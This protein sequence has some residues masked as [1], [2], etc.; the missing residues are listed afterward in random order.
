[1]AQLGFN[2]DELYDELLQNENMTVEMVAA[3]SVPPQPPQYVLAKYAMTWLGI[4][5]GL[6]KEKRDRSDDIPTLPTEPD[7]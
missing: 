2:P 1:M 5:M 6:Y 3:M 4:G 7:G